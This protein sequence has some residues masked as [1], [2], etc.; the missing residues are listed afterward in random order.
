MTVHAQ[1]RPVVLFTDDTNPKKLTYTKSLSKTFL[2]SNPIFPTR[3][4]D[5]LLSFEA[6]ELDLPN[7][8]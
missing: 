4:A 5:A 8:L 1:N 3:L 6:P 2:H 7:S